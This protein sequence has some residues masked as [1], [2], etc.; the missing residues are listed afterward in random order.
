MVSGRIGVWRWVVLCLVVGKWAAAALDPLALTYKLA[1]ANVGIVDAVASY[2]DPK[3]PSI[4]FLTTK[5]VSASDFYVSIQLADLQE[6]LSA[7]E[8]L[9]ASSEVSWQIPRS[10]GG[11]SLARFSHVEVKTT[12]RSGPAASDAIRCVFEMGD[13]VR[14]SENGVVFVPDFTHYGPAGKRIRRP[15]LA[16][17]VVWDQNANPGSVWGIDLGYRNGIDWRVPIQVQS[18]AVSRLGV[19]ISRFTVKGLFET[20]YELPTSVLRII[21]TEEQVDWEK[22]LRHE[23][24]PIIVSALPREGDLHWLNQNLSYEAMDPPKGKVSSLLSCALRLFGFGA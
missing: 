16:E 11:I 13:F 6:V 9:S 12:L 15:N 5:S 20:V 18:Q 3:E 10:S 22:S 24:L 19:P 17:L 21:P 23:A 4:L 14:E 8:P 1:V 2:P 7:L